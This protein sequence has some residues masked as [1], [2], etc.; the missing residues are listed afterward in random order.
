MQSLHSKKPELLIE[1]P[2]GVVLVV[3]SPASVFS[4]IYNSGVFLSMKTWFTR[5][6]GD[7]GASSPS[8]PGAGQVLKKTGREH[9]TQA[10]TVRL[11]DE[12][13]PPLRTLRDTSFPFTSH[14]S[15]VQTMK[16]T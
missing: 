15:I 16:F 9:L 1:K 3:H 6:V 5:M 14:P 10:T 13:A 12:R 4:I 7:G 11:Q 2:S 8:H